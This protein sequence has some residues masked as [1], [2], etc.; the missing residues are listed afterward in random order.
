MLQ[1]LGMSTSYLSGEFS[2]FYPLSVSF[3]LPGAAEWADRF[4]PACQPHPVVVAASREILKRTLRPLPFSTRLPCLP[5]V[6]NVGRRW[7]YC[8]FS[9]A[10]TWFMRTVRFAP[11]SAFWWVPKL[12]DKNAENQPCRGDELRRRK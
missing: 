11:V 5:G 2:L 9:L 4:H 12:Q 10:L 1:G 7:R 8:H 3:R 6:R